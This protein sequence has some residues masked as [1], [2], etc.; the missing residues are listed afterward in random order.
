MTAEQ[1]NG[2]RGVRENPYRSPSVSP[3]PSNERP[4]WREDIS[5]KT[6]GVLF[7]L[8]VLPYWSLGF[9]VSEGLVGDFRGA[10]WIRLS[11]L[12]Y[13]AHWSSAGGLIGLAFSRKTTTGGLIG[14]AIGLLA[15]AVLML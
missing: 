1:D 7:L 8:G 10:V 11:C 9:L 6:L 14:A 2:D 12:S 13:F 4:W 15:S 3:L 5:P